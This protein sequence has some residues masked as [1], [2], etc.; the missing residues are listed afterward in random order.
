MAKAIQGTLGKEDHAYMNMPAGMSTAATQARY[1]R[2]SGPRWG[3]LRLEIGLEYKRHHIR[4]NTH[5]LIQFLL[6]EIGNESE[7]RCNAVGE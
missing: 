7:H 6:K 2:A 4:L 5:V 1:S 3:K